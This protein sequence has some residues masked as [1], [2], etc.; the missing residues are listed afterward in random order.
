MKQRKINALLV[1]DMQYDFCNP[2]GALFVKGAVEDCERVSDWIRTNKEEIDQITLT[3]DSHTVLDIAHPGFWQDK[4]GN[5]PNPFTLIS[6]DDINNGTWTPRFFASNAIKYI[7]D[8]EAQG[9]YKHCIWPEHCLIGTK[10]NA[11]EDNVAAAVSEWVRQGKFAI[12]YV[13]KGTHP[14]TEHFGAF[15]A[16]VPL[17]NSPETQINQDLLGLLSEYHNVFLAG[18][19]KSHC[20]ATTLKQI[21]KYAPQ[22]ASKLVILEDTMSPV[23]GFENI[24]DSIY[25]EAKNQGVRFSTTAKEKLSQST[26]TV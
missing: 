14:L 19:A 8:L 22:L 10:G 4:D 5:S 20:V 26:V 24:A 23:P 16:Q 1:I 21:L 9:E 2:N 18:E 17:A 25:E 15:A 11:I 3:L 7:S 6:L 13:T 12:R